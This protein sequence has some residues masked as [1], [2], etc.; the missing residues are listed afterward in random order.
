MITLRRL[1][2]EKNP[3]A[4]KN[5]DKL[6]DIFDAQLEDTDSYVYLT[7]IKSI[8]AIGDVCPD[9]SLDRI[10]NIF[11]NTNLPIE[12][13]LKIGEALLLISQR[14]NEL[15][16]RYA[17]K[18]MSTYLRGTK[19]QDPS[20]RASSLSNLAEV[21]ELLH[22]AVQPYIEEVMACICS[23]LSSDKEPEVRRGAVNVFTQLL[24]GMDKEIFKII[25]HHLKT[26]YQ[27]LKRVS[28]QDS[29]TICQFHA[30]IALDTL[31]DII[32]QLFQV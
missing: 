18:V 20:I 21:C 3:E 30:Q 25:P 22:Y 28:S 14:Q 23:V 27:T 11:L 31:N 4:L 19:E 8:S 13:R 15:L 10:C 6:F 26:I 12:T 5:I 24:R 2:L 29:D 7:A 9:T 17:N 1:L 32:Q 16:P